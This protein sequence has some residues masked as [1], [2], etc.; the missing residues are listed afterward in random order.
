MSKLDLE[1]VLRTKR[2]P[3]KPMQVVEVAAI[4]TVSSTSMTANPCKSKL[5]SPNVLVRITNSS[6]TS[7][8]FANLQ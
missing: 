5:W 6:A 8:P 4:V 2:S 7:R 3:R 1:V